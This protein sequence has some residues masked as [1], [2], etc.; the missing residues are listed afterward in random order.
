MNVEKDRISVKFP[1]AKPCLA[2]GSRLYVIGSQDGMFP[3]MGEH[4]GKEM[5][6]VWAPPIKLLD[7]FWLRC[8]EEWAVQADEFTALPYGCEFVYENLNGL[9]V[10]RFQFVPQNE[11][12]LFLRIRLEN[13]GSSPWNG[14]VS[15]SVKT[16]LFPVWLSDRLGIQDGEDAV[17]REG[18]LVF[19]KDLDNPWSFYMG[20]SGEYELK[21]GGEEECPQGRTPGRGCYFTMSCPLSLPAGE[22]RELWFTLASSAVSPEEA[23]K[24]FFRVRGRQDELLE[25]KRE[26]YQAMQEA[27]Q[28]S[29]PGK[30]LLEQVYRWTQYCNDWIARD[31]KNVGKGVVAGYAEFP[32][33]FGHDTAYIVPALLMQG[34]EELAKSTLRLIKAVSARE[35]GNGRVVHEIATNGV[36][37]YEGMS[38]ETPQFADAVWRVY[39]WTGDK[40]FLREMYPFCRQGGEYL[41]SLCQDGLPGGY[42]V[43]EIAGLDCVCCDTSAHAVRENQVLMEMSLALGEKENAAIY[44]ERMKRTLDAFERVMWNPELGIYGDMAASRE[45]IL[46]RARTWQYTLKGFPITDVDEVEGYESCKKDKSPE[47]EESKRRLRERMQAV[48]REAE[49]MEEGERRAFYLF[50]LGHSITPIEY[51]YV[52]QERARSIL[53]KIGSGFRPSRVTGGN[54]MPIGTGHRIMAEAMA[55]NPEKVLYGMELVAESFGKVTPG[56]TSEIY[57]DSGCFVQAWNSFATMWPVA[58]AIFG[59]R[60]DAANKRVILSPCLCPEMDGVTLS[61]LKIGGESFTLRVHVQEETW[62]EVAAPEGWEILSGNGTELK[63]GRC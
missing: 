58:G 26:R 41:E 46:P 54:I 31:V 10:E 33:W 56:A 12:A 11:E 55:G 37:F 21:L 17:R 42:G 23:K 22:S 44:E 6:G 50:D 32:W 48:I 9:W 16:E 24:T 8:G 20:V 34:E 59:V 52:E 63:T 5:W 35:N 51:G 43:T 14:P 7:G 29:M 4:I 28:L 13:R 2:T 53:E 38:T 47:E 45:E 18:D 3:Q 30:P 61:N 62:V 57:P 49:A 27:A 15:L 19:G 1:A 25:E 40:D 39:C 60:P 36:V